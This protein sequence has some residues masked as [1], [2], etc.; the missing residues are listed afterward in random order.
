MFGGNN[1][2]FKEHLDYFSTENPN[3][4][5]PR[6]TGWKDDKDFLV[7]TGYNTKCYLLNA[8][9]MRM[10]NLTVAYTFNKKQLKHIGISNLKVYVTCD[11]LFT[12]TKLPKQFD[13]ETLNQVN[14]SA[15]GDAKNTAP[16]LTSPMKQNGNGMVYPMNRNFVFGL[17]FTF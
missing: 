16:G 8:A 15:G 1:Y 9:Y 12:I 2:N 5:L 17:D 10:K 11:N 3:G 7:N 14:M 13:P 6:L 4:Y